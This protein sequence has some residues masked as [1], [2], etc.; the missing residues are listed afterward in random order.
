MERGEQHDMYII[1]P[2][3]VGELCYDD[4]IATKISLVSHIRSFCGIERQC[5]SFQARGI[6]ERHDAGQLRQEII[7]SHNYEYRDRSSLTCKRVKT[8]SS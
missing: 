8:Y 3:S 4:V 5:T 2:T 7:D 6:H 1:V